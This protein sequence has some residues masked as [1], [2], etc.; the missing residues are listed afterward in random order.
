MIVTYKLLF[1]TETHGRRSKSRNKLV[2]QQN[3]KPKVGR[4]IEGFTRLKVCT[5]SKADGPAGAACFDPR[6]VA[7]SAALPL[8]G[9]CCRGAVPPFRDVPVA[10]GGG[11]GGGRGGFCFWVPPLPP[12][13]PTSV[14]DRRWLVNWLVLIAE[15]RNTEL[16][17]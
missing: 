16:I 4:N 17:A 6:K 3:Q 14:L 13:P 12:P 11:G 8:A 9:R 15:N 5:W 10:W 1:K 7:L 2:L